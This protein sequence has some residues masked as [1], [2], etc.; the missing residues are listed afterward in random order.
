M[1]PAH[2]GSAEERLSCSER[3]RRRR[4]AG[5]AFAVVSAAAT[6]FGVLALVGLLG[7]L[8]GSGAGRL[9]LDFLTRFAS[10]VPDLAGVRAPLVGSIVVVASATLL[11]LPIAIGAAVYL[12]EYAPRTIWTR[13]IRAN[14]ATL[15]GVPSIVY[16]LLGLAIFVR[17]LGLGRSVLSGA[18]TLALLVLPILV[19]AA[20]EAIRAVPDSVREA[21]YGLGAT[22]WQVVRHQVLPLAL[23]GILTGAILAVGRAVGETAPLILVGAAGYLAFTPTGPGDEFT[24]LPLQIFSWIQRPEEGFREL[25]AAAILVLLLL[26][27]TLN[28]VAI[29][30]RHRA[31]TRT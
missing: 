14:I 24:V 5:S 21:A 28:A 20:Q 4:L 22:R 15:A 11:A 6:C 30:L 16:G 29:L 12:E 25:A 1:S 26:L 23:P 8:I 17:F 18:A 10:R 19:I 13:M 27:L 31:E 2:W 9:D 3:L 7:Y